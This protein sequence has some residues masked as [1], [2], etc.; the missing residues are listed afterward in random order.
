[1]VIETDLIV[2]HR[3]PTNNG[4]TWTLASRLGGMLRDA[5]DKFGE[6]DRS[7]TILSIEFCGDFP[8]VWYPANCRQVVIQLTESCLTNL[9]H[10][11]K[12]E[13]LGRKLAP[14]KKAPLRRQPRHLN[15]AAALF[16]GDLAATGSQG[17]R[18]FHAVCR[19]GSR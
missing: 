11:P 6:R 14:Q 12:A 9:H 7:Y 8:Q 13:A 5:E 17:L 4:Y 16:K 15:R 18:S 19:A 1:M 3:L 10:R 2:A